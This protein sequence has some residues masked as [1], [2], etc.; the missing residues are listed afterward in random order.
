M[1]QS[2]N[3]WRQAVPGEALQQ[4]AAAAVPTIGGKTDGLQHSAKKGR[5]LHLT[6]CARQSQDKSFPPE[7]SSLG[8]IEFL[9]DGT[10]NLDDISW[11]VQGVGCIVCSCAR[12]TVKE[13]T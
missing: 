12:A 4:P 8:E 11:Q 1:P 9:D 13:M 5:H 10:Y 7:A 6:S 2:Y 3:A